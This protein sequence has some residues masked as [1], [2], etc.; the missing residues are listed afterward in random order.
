MNLK[1]QALHFNPWHDTRSDT[2]SK[3]TWANSHVQVNIPATTCK[4]I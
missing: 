3:N 2:D 4:T 1:V